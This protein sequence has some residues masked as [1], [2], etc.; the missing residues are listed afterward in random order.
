MSSR[1]RLCGTANAG[2]GGDDPVATKPIGSGALG[3]ARTD[4][5]VETVQ[6]K[7]QNARSHDNRPTRAHS[8]EKNEN[9]R[10]VNCRVRTRPIRSAR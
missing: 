1:R 10:M 7:H 4:R 9:H 3:H 2:S 6:P 8:I 5:F